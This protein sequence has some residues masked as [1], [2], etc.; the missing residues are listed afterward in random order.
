MNTNEFFK[1]KPVQIAICVFSMLCCAYFIYGFVGLVRQTHARAVGREFAAAASELKKSPAGIQ[2]AGVFLKRLKAIGP[3]YF[4]PEVKQALH[5]YI[6]AM[7]QGLDA[8]KEGKDTSQYDAAVADAKQ[9]L[10][11]GVEKCN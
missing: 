3:G 6:S 10:I 8:L 2:S 9:R 7:E 5:D 4:P 11:T 1:R